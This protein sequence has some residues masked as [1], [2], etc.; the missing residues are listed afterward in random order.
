[1]QYIIGDYID[2]SEVNSAQFSGC[3]SLNNVHSSVFYKGVKKF[4]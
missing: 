1:M 3:A 2:Y 4:D